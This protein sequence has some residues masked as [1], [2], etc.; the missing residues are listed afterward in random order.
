MTEAAR[1]RPTPVFVLGLERSG[2]TWLANI[3]G[4]HPDAV[5]VQSEDHFGVHES[6]FFS[7]FARAYG[8]LADDANFRRFAEDFTTSDYYLLSGL[9]AKWLTERRPRTYAEAFG[10]VMDEMANRAGAR[11]WIEKSPSH[12]LLAEDLARE[13]PDARFVGIVRRPQAVINSHLSLAG[14]PVPRYPRRARTVFRMARDC[15]LYERW[16]SR[17]CRGRDDAVFTTY[18]ELRADPE[19]ETARICEHIGIEF[20]P[21]MLD[22]P[23]RRNTSFDA[24]RPRS[25]SLGR[26][27]RM[28]VGASLAA[29]RLVPVSALERQVERSQERSGIQWPRWVW[30]RRDAA[31]TG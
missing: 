9:P 30:R 17:F 19:R 8:D 4:N 1:S 28:I 20:T 24:A 25:K 15:S 18:E 21:S 27:D 5:A 12:T 16:L 29:L 3:L 26:T 11:V 7:H 22:L 23:W 6:I 10:L 2:T 13:F 14:E 31:A